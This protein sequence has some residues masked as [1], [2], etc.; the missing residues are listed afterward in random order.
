MGP[1]IF[2]FHVSQIIKIATFVVIGLIVLFSLIFYFASRSE[3][4]PSVDAGSL[5]PHT[6]F[7]PG[8]YRSRI[9]LN[10]LP[11]FVEVTVSEDAITEI[12]FEELTENQ[13]AFYPLLE[14]TMARISQAILENQ[15]LSVTSTTDDA[16]TSQLIFSAIYRAVGEARGDFMDGDFGYAYDEAMTN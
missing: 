15:D 8:T 16:V 3:S 11:L 4:T 12:V 10:Y 1:K 5:Y 6:Q 7:T 9:H 2:V 13:M 14:P